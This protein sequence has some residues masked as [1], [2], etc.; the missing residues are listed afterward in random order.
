MKKTERLHL[1]CGDVYLR[2]NFTNIDFQDKD[3]ILVSNFTKETY[4][5]F[6]RYSAT[7]L[8]R[9]YVKPIGSLKG[10]I[11]CDSF[12]DIRT[13][14]NYK[15]GS[16]NEIVAF[17]VLEHFTIIDAKKAL[18]RWISLLIQGGIL[19]ICVP[20]IKEICSRIL[21]ASE[22]ENNFLERDH[23]Y[24][25]LFGTHN[26]NYQLDGHKS[27]WSQMMLMKELTNLGMNVE[28]H[29]SPTD[30]KFNPSLYITGVKK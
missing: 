6:L 15:I 11:I 12:D 18:I 23:S 27:C 25:L 20:D 5:G 9:Y 28:M 29:N 8:D 7:V 2:D 22:N 1:G 30:F 16:V 14:D 19:R 3:S 4:L 21:N 10:K 17:H 26:R 13:L 24:R